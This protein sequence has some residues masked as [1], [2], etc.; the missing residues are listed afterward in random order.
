MWHPALFKSIAIAD[1]V[2]IRSRLHDERV[3]IQ[4]GV[5]TQ[6][7]RRRRGQMAPQQRLPQRR[8]GALNGG[9][10]EDVGDILTGSAD[11]A[12]IGDGTGV[13]VRARMEAGG[14]SAAR[15]KAGMHGLLRP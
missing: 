4:K 11:D 3:P 1:E 7:V 2:Q 6:R 8:H 10:P 9:A 15:K 5:T 13:R 14:S 12:S